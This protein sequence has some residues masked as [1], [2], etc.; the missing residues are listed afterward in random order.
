M[1]NSGIL[2]LER[3]ACHIHKAWIMHYQHLASAGMCR[4]QF[5][6]T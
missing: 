1:S 2:A 5:V 3:S 6:F 4:M